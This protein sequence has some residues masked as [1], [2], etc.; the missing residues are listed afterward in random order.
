[1]VLADFLLLLKGKDT[2]HRSIRKFS[3]SQQQCGPVSE[4]ASV[5]LYYCDAEKMEVGFVINGYVP[6]TEVLHL[7]TNVL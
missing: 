3:S 4:G 1:M 6:G 7:A 2:S 5:Q